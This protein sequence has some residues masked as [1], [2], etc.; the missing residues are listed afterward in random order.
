M[1]MRNAAQALTNVHPDAQKDNVKVVMVDIDRPLPIEQQELSKK[2]FHGSIPHVVVLGAVGSALYN[3]SGEVEDAVI[4]ASR[5][6]PA[7]TSGLCLTARLQ[8]SR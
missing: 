2:Y 3:P 7:L 8:S 5:Q 1:D 4:S 6:G